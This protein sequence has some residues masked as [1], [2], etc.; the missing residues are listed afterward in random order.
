MRSLIEE[1]LDVAAPE[2]YLPNLKELEKETVQD[3]TGQLDKAKQEN[4]S[5]FTARV[6]PN[7]DHEVH[8]EIHRA[9]LEAG[10]MGPERYTPEQMQALT[11]HVNDHVRISGGAVPPVQEGAE[12]GM[13]QGMAQAFS[14][15]QGNQDNQQT[16]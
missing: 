4:R 15:Q 16:L 9:A 1:G 10:G 12:Q 2:I 3:K 14:G 11:S 5:P 13:A 6:M 7:D 8:L